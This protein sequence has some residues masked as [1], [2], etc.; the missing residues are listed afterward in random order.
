VLFYVAGFLGFGV[1]SVISVSGV[2]LRRLALGVRL[3]FRFR[4]SGLGG[5]RLFCRGWIVLARERS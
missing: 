5:C 1:V 4:A 3:Y 2:D